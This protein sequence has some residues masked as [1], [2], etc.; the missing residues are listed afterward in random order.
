MSGKTII[1]GYAP[2]GLPLYKIRPYFPEA[3]GYIKHATRFLDHEKVFVRQYAQ[4]V[5]DNC[6]RILD[7]LI[8]IEEFENN[9]PLV[10]DPDVAQ[11]VHMRN[12]VIRTYEPE[13]YQK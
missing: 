5:V 7:N 1:D 6:Q 11:L 13:K 2:D 12:T 10:D 8:T 9:I 4:M 3:E